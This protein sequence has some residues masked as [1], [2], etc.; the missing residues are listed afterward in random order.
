MYS[1][2]CCSIIYKNNFFFNEERKSFS[3][4]VAKFLAFCALM[5]NRNTETVLEEERD[6]LILSLS[7]KGENTAG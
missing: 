4:F 6:G 7:G 5:P 2:L 1:C 3:N